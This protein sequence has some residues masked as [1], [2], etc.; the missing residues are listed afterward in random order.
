MFRKSVKLISERKNMMF[1]GLM[2]FL[3]NVLKWVMKLKFESRFIS[4]IGKIDLS[5]L[6]KMF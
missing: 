2:M 4:Y 1:F 3:V 6:E 5:M